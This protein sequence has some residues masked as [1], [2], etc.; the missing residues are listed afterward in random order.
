VVGP[1]DVLKCFH[2]HTTITSRQDRKRLDLAGLIPDVSCERCH[3]PAR[4]HVEAARRGSSGDDL[5]MPMGPGR[6]TAE[7]QLKLCGQCHRHPDTEPADA[8]RTDN[9]D[10]IRFQPV[11]LMQSACYKKSDGRLSC[12]NCHDPHARPSDDPSFYEKACLE[13]HGRGAAPTEAPGA[14]LKRVPC[15]VSPRSGCIDCHMRRR[16]TGQQVLYTDHWICV[17]QGTGPDAKAGAG[18]A[19]AS[20]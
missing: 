7:S 18:G 2:C 5:A 17:L 15:P 8:I 12:L 16:E 9:R 1:S 14:G 10:I 11:G 6:W 13:C 3:G 4:A 20:K 19:A